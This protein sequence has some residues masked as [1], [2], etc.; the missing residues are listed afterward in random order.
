VAT[1]PSRSLCCEPSSPKLVRQPC[2]VPLSII[3]LLA[4]RPMAVV[5]F[6]AHCD[7]WEDH[8]SEPSGHG[9]WVYEAVKEG[10]VIP[11]C[12]VQIGIRSPGEKHTI[13]YIADQ[14]GIIYTAR[15]LRGVHTTGQI[16]EVRTPHSFSNPFMY[17]VCC[18]LQMPSRLATRLTECLPHTSLWT[19][20]A[21]IPPSPQ[22]PGPL[23]SEACPPH[24]WAMTT[25]LRLYC[26][27]YD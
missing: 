24:R 2:C 22:A 5:H 21:L 16:A 8:F 1:T 14:G 7:T 12:F 3:T 15:D 27:Y 25:L 11:E 23:K 13:E 10:L 17:P 20:T 26:Y 4:G 19:S 6:D 18:R 9:T